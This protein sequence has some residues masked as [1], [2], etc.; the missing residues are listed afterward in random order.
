MIV[1]ENR[2]YFRSHGCLPLLAVV[3]LMSLWS[4]FSMII[5]Y[6]RAVENIR[7]DTSEVFA[8]EE[9]DQRQSSDVAY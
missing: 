6:V 2:F 3:G 9:A 5:L 8:D 1:K 4:G 7:W